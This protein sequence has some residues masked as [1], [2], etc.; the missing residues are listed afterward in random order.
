MVKK[1]TKYTDL[2]TTLK[3]VG[4]AVFVNFYYDFKNAALS[5]SEIIAK[6]LKDN[7]GSKSKNQNFRIARA[8]HI[9]EVDGQLDALE[10]IINSKKIS[11]A[12]REKAKAIFEKEVQLVQALQDAL[13]E[14][15]LIAALN[16]SIAYSE[17]SEFEYSNVLERPRKIKTVST[18]LYPRSKKVSENALYKAGLLCEVDADHPLFTRKNSKENYTEPHH[19]VPLYAQKDFPDINLDREQNVV[20]L[21][22]YCHNLLH[23][24]ADIDDVLCKLYLSRKDLLRQIG[25]DISYE[26]LKS[27]YL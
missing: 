22:S 4:K 3:A 9:F 10:I 11:P 27:Y 14:R 8:R 26:K 7:P 12:D 13:D 15:K 2:H 24:G 19:L 21:C 5:N 16:K 17:S 25:I 23:Y 6:L 1:D 18:L 20:S